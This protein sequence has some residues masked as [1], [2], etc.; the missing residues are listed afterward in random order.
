M[1]GNWTTVL[2]TQLSED[3][4]RAS[5]NPTEEREGGM[6]VHEDSSSVILPGENYWPQ[7]YWSL[8]PVNCCCAWLWLFWFCYF[9]ALL[10]VNKTL[11]S[12]LISLT[13]LISLTCVN[14]Y[15]WKAEE[16]F[17][18]L[19]AEYFFVRNCAQSKQVQH[20]WLWDSLVCHLPLCCVSPE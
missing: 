18:G 4:E 14:Q 2:T 1:F 9:T 5:E 13:S 17:Q 15:W 3:V 19:I 7:N 10:K 11:I 16:V 6:E 8:G 20:I 12:L